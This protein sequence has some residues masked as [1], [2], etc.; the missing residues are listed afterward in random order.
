M[1]NDFDKKKHVNRLR[2]RQF[3][4]QENKCEIESEI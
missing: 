3:I 1:A 2:H 4:V